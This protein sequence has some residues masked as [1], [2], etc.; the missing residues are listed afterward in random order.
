MAPHQSGDLALTRLG[1]L[2]EQE[3]QRGVL[4]LVHFFGV[5]PTLPA[6]SPKPGSY[7]HQLRG[8]HRQPGGSHA[9]REGPPNVSLQIAESVSTLMLTRF[10][11]MALS[12]ARFHCDISLVD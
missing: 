6:A 3:V 12:G 7:H 10:R 4:L 1:L 2:P 9:G 8:S 11:Q 5:R